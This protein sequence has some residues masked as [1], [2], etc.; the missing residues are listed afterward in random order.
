I[1][2]AIGDL[3]AIGPTL[4]GI[5]NVLFDLEVGERAI[6]T[7]NECIER[8]RACGDLA[9]EGVALVILGRIA[10]GNER[11]DEAIA[12]I[13]R[14]LSLLEDGDNPGLLAF[15]QTTLGFTHLLAGRPAAA[16]DAYH[17]GMT[18]AR[19]LDDRWRIADA[20][21][22]FAEIASRRGQDPLA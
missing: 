6:V 13:E 22:G 17:N 3:A 7:L 9:E 10:A 5:G 18:L 12:L 2:K 14:A 11:S 8:S 15:A 1:S 16:V 4:R 19:G 21:A 20:L